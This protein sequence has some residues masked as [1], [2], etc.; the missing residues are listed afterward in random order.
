MTGRTDI[1]RRSAPIAHGGAYTSD[2]MERMQGVI[3]AVCSELGIAKGRPE[4]EAVARRVLAAYET[5]R[6][7]PLNLVDAGLGALQ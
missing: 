5:G 4:R 3:D 1:L 2:D 6:R 7:Q